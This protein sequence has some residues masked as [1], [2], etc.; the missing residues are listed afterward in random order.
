MRSRKGEKMKTKKVG[1]GGRAGERR[2][3]QGSDGNA[4]LMYEDGLGPGSFLSVVRTAGGIE[5]AKLKFSF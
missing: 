1:G 5:P 2:M 4:K 3:A